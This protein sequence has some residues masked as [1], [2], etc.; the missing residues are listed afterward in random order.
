MFHGEHSVVRG[1]TP[2]DGTTALPKRSVNTNNQEKESIMNAV[3]EVKDVVIEGVLTLVDKACTNA[4]EALATANDVLACLPAIVEASD[5]RSNRDSKYW[6]LSEGVVR[7]YKVLALIVALGDDAD[8]TVDLY[9]A[10]RVVNATFKVKGISVEMMT[11][12]INGADTVTEAVVAL[13]GL[14]PVA[15]DEDDETEGDETE[16]EGEGDD[17][18]PTDA[19][20]MLR[21]LT[22]PMGS[23]R[24]VAEHSKA[25][26][27]FN[28]EEKVAFDA[29][30]S[31]IAEIASAQAMVQASAP[32]AV[33]A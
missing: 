17:T 8:A 26:V 10:R 19:V 28:E 3:R 1:S 2:P 29:M 20:K 9:T 16:G 4:D 13:Q 24:K 18:P 21:W 31:V 7:R 5:G 25:G 33:P 30:L 15:T 11:N 27:K 32:V 23:L 14:T 6:G 12:A 22:S